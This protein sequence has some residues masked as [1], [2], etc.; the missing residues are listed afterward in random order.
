MSWCW[1]CREE[2]SEP[3]FQHRGRLRSPS[4]GRAVLSAPCAGPGCQQLD[5]AL[6]PG[7]PLQGCSSEQ[8]ARWRWYSPR[9][10]RPG[11]LRRRPGGP[12]PQG[13][14]VGAE[15]SITACSHPLRR[16]STRGCASLPSNSHQLPLGVNK[17][18]HPPQTA[19]MKVRIGLRQAAAPATP[20]PPR[21]SPAGAAGQRGRRAGPRRWLS[22]Q[23]P[24]LRQPWEPAAAPVM[25]PR[26]LV[27]CTLSRKVTGPDN[28]IYIAV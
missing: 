5:P 7:N 13:L 14:R 17:C 22:A 3:A 9:E 4:S 6:R 16:A 12:A 25:S 23:P 27:S 19:N 24:A 21:C 1:V 26:L 28:I 18:L 15:Q 8:K 10:S 20:L 2:T 11:L